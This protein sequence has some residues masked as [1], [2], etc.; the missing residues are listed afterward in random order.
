MRYVWCYAYCSYF[1]VGFILL[2][3][4]NFHKVYVS[5]NYGL[6]I[7]LAVAILLSFALKPKNE[8][9]VE[10]QEAPGRKK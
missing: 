8:R 1:A 3:F 7:V 5:M 6:H 10:V 9:K 2:S 4:E